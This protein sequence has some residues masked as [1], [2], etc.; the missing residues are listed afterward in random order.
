VIKEIQKYDFN[1]SGVVVIPNFY[2]ENIVERM[3]KSCKS[4][5][6]Q[7]LYFKNDPELFMDFMSDERI[8]EIC[9]NF[10]GDWFRFDHELAISQNKES[11]PYLHGGQFGS[12]GT[13]T[14]VSTGD[15]GT[16]W[17]GQLTV[18]LALTKQN[19][20]TG[21]FSYIPGSHHQIL[22][23]RNGVQLTEIWNYYLE[24]NKT[25]TLDLNPGDLYIFSE[26]IA[27]GQAKWKVDNENRKTLYIKY[28]PGYMA[29]QSYDI[30]KDYLKYATKPIHELLLSPPSVRNG[31][32]DN[33][34]WRKSTRI[35][36][37]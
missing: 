5:D 24:N 9:R 11:K 13:C 22:Q 27:H 26:A 25:T 37:R 7:S 20:D 16:S 19:Q 36:S 17:C 10:I 1:T 14:Y 2:N 23:G 15:N 6:L 8:L 30:T 28:V 29:W 3:K 12:Q 4:D 31:T 18:G 35:R 34:T 21:G 33:P 32:Y